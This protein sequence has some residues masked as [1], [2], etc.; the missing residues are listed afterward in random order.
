M[1]P[2]QNYP[3]PLCFKGLCVL[4]GQELLDR[5]DA[6]LELSRLGD[7]VPTEHAHTVESLGLQPI[8]GRFRSF[9]SSEESRAFV[10]DHFAHTVHPVL[11]RHVCKLDRVLGDHDDGEVHVGRDSEVLASHRFHALDYKD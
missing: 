6:D 2:P 1:G 3:N 10:R 5:E 7:H 4:E 11:R 8:L 9:L